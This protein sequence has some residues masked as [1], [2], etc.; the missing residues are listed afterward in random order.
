MQL[1]AVPAHEPGLRLLEFNVVPTCNW[2]CVVPLV[3]VHENVTEEPGRTLPGAGLVIA[4]DANAVALV[5][6]RS[7]SSGE[8]I[9]SFILVSSPFFNVAFRVKSGPF[10]FDHVKFGL[11]TFDHRAILN[12]LPA[13]AIDLL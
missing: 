2:Y 8:R 3:A 6:V 12:H 13:V 7:K 5:N 10:T 1:V 9:L 11:I 4:D